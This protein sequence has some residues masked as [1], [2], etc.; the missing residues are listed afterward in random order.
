MGWLKHED[1]PSFLQ[2]LD[3]FVLPSLYEG[4]GVAAVEAAA[5]GLPIVASD[6]D[7]IP[8]PGSRVAWPFYS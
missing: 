2:S 4:F 5:C 8:G 6:V 1:L 7:G 3:V